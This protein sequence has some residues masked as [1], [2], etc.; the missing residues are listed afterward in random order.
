MGRNVTEKELHYLQSPPVMARLQGAYIKAS[1]YVGIHHH[2]L[3][4]ITWLEWRAKKG[5]TRQRKWN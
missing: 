3:Q 4:A 2:E 1:N 5:I